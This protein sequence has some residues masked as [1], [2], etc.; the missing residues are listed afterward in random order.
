[1]HSSASA[2]GHNDHAYWHASRRRLAPL[3]GEAHMADLLRV[4]GADG[5]AGT[6]WDDPL[7]VAVWCLRDGAVL[8]HEGGPTE[9]LFVVRSGSLK[10]V[11]LSEDGYNQVVSFAGPGQVLGFESLHRGVHRNS[12]VAMEVSSV[13]AL[14]VKG[15]DRRR[16]QSAALDMALQMAISRQLDGAGDMAELMAAV[17]ADVRLS[18]FLLWMSRR[19]A[20]VGQSPLR[21]HLR[22]CRRDVASLLGVAHETVSRSFSNLA[23]EGLI[24][25]LNREIDILDMPRLIE[26]ARCTRGLSESAQASIPTRSLA[27]ATDGT[28]HSAS[29]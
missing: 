17:A 5:D 1:M 11:K 12:A 14:P 22:M 8:F 25:V 15:L 23:S 27:M 3:S 4:M 9:S 21:F 26:R 13:F 10:S 18:R 28:A 20:S 24:K 19:L 29:A 2:L 7:N 16:Q 6:T